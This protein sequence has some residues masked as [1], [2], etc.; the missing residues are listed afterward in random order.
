M[1]TLTIDLGGSRVKMTVIAGENMRPP[2]IFPV[3]HKAPLTDTLHMVAARSLELL[4]GM[5]ISPDAVALALPGIVHHGRAVACNGKY[6][7]AVT[8]DWKGWP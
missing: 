7:D 1:N 3:D 4:Q 2:V 6:S 5:H 8:F